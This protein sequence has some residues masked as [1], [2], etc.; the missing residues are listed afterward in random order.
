LLIP[1][2]AQNIFRGQARHGEELAAGVLWFSGKTQTSVCSYCAWRSPAADPGETLLST[3]LVC[4]HQ[5][6]CRLEFE[7]AWSAAP[8]GGLFR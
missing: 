6:I 8:D 5:P 4:V 2:N 1:A 3:R 7:T